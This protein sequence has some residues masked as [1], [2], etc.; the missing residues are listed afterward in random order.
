MN[1]FEFRRMLVETSGRFDLVNDDF[2][3][4]G[5][6]FFISAGQRYLETICYWDKQ[7][8][9][10]RETLSGLSVCMLPGL[11]AVESVM[12]RLDSSSIWVELIRVPL[13][14]ART[15]V[16]NNLETGLD[17]PLFYALVRS[18]GDVTETVSDDF[19]LGSGQ[20]QDVTEG[21]NYDSVGIFLSPLNRSTESLHL[22]VHGTFRS[23]V[24]SNDSES[25]FWTSEWPTLLLYATSRE[26]EIFQRNMAGVREWDVALQNIL[27]ANEMDMVEDEAN[28][29]SRME[30]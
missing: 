24:L 3:D 29:V 13:S 19:F 25:N 2:S 18:R 17:V 20:F 16:A 5:A 26:L 21:Q 9:V 12:V 28:T 27:T 7:K 30:G 8:A 1:L 4:N 6:N 11:R 23:S 10:F 22:E 14:Q 15:Y